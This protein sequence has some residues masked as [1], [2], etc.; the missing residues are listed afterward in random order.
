[1]YIYI[2]IMFQN[3]F[4]Y[5]SLYKKSIEAVECNA[6]N[7]GVDFASLDINLIM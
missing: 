4:V 2:Y 1:M 3:S 7:Q 5:T 6:G